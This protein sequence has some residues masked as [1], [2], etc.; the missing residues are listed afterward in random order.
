LV[1]LRYIVE[2]VEANPTGRAEQRRTQVA[3]KL[4]VAKNC[5]AEQDE[6]L[7][8]QNGAYTGA[9]AGGAAGKCEV[10]QGTRRDGGLGIASVQSA[11]MTHMCRVVQMSEQAR[12]VTFEVG[13]AAE[14]E[15]GRRGSN[16]QRTSGN[17]QSVTR[18]AG[19]CSSSRQRSIGCGAV[20]RSQRCSG[21]LGLRSH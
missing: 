11:R 18:Q 7:V 12:S 10:D 1:L 9:V 20:T 5:G 4:T 21:I 19:P 13:A 6:A 16:Q 3:T 15:L 14:D 8:Y 2:S 17:G